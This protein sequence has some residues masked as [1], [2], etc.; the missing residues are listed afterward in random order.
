MSILPILSLY[1]WR[2]G[3]RP[4]RRLEKAAL[5][6]LGSR[7]SAGH[8][9]GGRASTIGLGKRDDIAVWSMYVSVIM[10]F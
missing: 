2:D 1:Y 4:Q 10:L 8:V 3:W 9:S 6:F 5:C 7:A